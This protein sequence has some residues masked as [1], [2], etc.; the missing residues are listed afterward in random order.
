M[1]ADTS[2][3]TAGERGAAA[4]RGP[5][6]A[7]SRPAGTR[8][9]EAWSAGTWPETAR[10]ALAARRRGGGRGARS[11]GRYA[12]TAA[13]R[14]GAQGGVFLGRE[15]ASGAEVVVK[16][17]RARQGAGPAAADAREALRHEAAVLDRLAGQGLA[18]RTVELVEH[19]DSLFLV[20]ER[21][22]GQPLDGWVAARLRRDGSPDVDWAEAGP[23]AHR[24]LDLVERVHAQGLVL[25]DLSPDKVVV[26][27]DGTPR[28]ADLARAAEAGR[29]AG[30][31]GAP[32]YRAP[33]HG[34]GRLAPARRR[35][36]DPAV[37]RYALGGL[38]FLLATGHDPLLP[39]DLPAARP[40]A[41]RLGR[42][43]ALAARTGGTARRL[44]PA[45][46]GLRAEDPRRR[47]TVARARAALPSA[48]GGPGGPT[49]V[50]KT[51]G[52]GGA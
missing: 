45:I 51:P 9:A 48:P 30:S 22:A 35:L 1:G 20:Q 41:D 50:A 21:I 19:G 4:A 32:G 2:L 11:A 24:L 31:A 8:P 49:A 43:L 13:V 29:P 25:R 46:L 37:D 3:R 6:A 52:A 39:E 26:G 33:E 47:W 5:A 14:H 18:P 38:L 10:A 16:Q 34:P 7:G 28:L 27:P 42:W 40:V 15:T 12:L 44:A 23:V 17:A 36:A